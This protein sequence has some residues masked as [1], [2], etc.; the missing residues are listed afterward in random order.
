VLRDA[1]QLD[2]ISAAYVHGPPLT[3]RA[4]PPK[5]IMSLCPMAFEEPSWRQL[6]RGFGSPYGR[7]AGPCVLKAPAW[8][9]PRIRCVRLALFR[10]CPALNNC[11]SRV[12]RGGPYTPKEPQCASQRGPD[13]HSHAARAGGVHRRRGTHCP[14]RLHMSVS[15]DWLCCGCPADRQGGH[16]RP[17]IS[18]IT[19]GSDTYIPRR[20]ITPW[21]IGATMRQSAGGLTN[22]HA[23]RGHA[24]P[25]VAMVHLPSPQEGL[26]HVPR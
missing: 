22:T 1:L 21:P 12:K 2:V 14:R 11:W 13:Q 7:Q 6:N 17:L 16:I 19:H 24:D 18:G 15:G 20:S 10:G 3:H 25:C 8:L 5:H 9:P 26:K 4:G 23:R